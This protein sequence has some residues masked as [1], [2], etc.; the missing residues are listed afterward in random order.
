MRKRKCGA[1][2]SA[3]KDISTSS[4]TGGKKVRTDSIQQP[5]A[6][7]TASHG[8]GAV[9]AAL[10]QPIDYTSPR[11]RHHQQCAFSRRRLQQPWRVHQPVPMLVRGL[12]GQGSGARCSYKKC[13]GYDQLSV[14]RVAFKTIYRCEECI[15]S[16]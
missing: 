4:S 7:T 8:T 9:H 12:D 15:L 3:T 2:P 5:F 10:P 14:R 11:G 16:C 6:S 1:P 13:L